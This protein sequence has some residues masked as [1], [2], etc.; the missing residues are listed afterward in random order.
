MKNANTRRETIPQ[1]NQETKLLTNQKEDSHTNIILPLITK[2]TGS[3]NHFSLISLNIGEFN[4]P[5]KRCKLTDWICKQEPAYWC[6]QE[7]P[8]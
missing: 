2:I 7:T 1:K 6:I 8:Q 3:K 4:F 5:I